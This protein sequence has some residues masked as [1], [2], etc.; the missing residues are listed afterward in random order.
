MGGW[1][2][3]FSINSLEKAKLGNFLHLLYDCLALPA[4]ST[5]RWSSFKLN[6][7]ELALNISKYIDYLNVKNEQMNV[8]HHSSVSVRS[9]GDECDS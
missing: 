6:M 3:T 1:I 7:E 9:P 5:S 8:V 4:I 2:I